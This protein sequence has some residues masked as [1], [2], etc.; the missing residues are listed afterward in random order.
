LLS[1]SLLFFRKDVTLVS[2][3]VPSLGRGTRNGE[4]LR[5]SWGRFLAC[6]WGR[7]FWETAHSMCTVLS[8]GSLPRSLLV[9][10][11][12]SRSCHTASLAWVGGRKRS[13]CH[14][15]S[16]TWWRKYEGR[17]GNRPLVF[18]VVFLSPEGP[19]SHAPTP[20]RSS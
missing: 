4:R 2:H 12:T 9:C 17:Q 13:L 16:R 7:W 3:C 1:R 15:T 6:I 19:R 8:L 20:L 10:E 14:A 18:F 5:A 11:K